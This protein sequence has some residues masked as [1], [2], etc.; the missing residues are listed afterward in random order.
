MLALQEPVTLPEM[1]DVLRR[2]GF[3]R[4]FAGLL[5]LTLP[6]AVVLQDDEAS[7]YALSALAGMGLYPLAL[8][9]GAL[10]GDA[11]RRGATPPPRVASLRRWVVGLRWSLAF[12]WGAW[13]AGGHGRYGSRAWLTALVALAAGASAA[14]AARPLPVT[15]RP[16]PDTS[17]TTVSPSRI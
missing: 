7:W 15:D 9:A 6:F 3:G 4:L 5:A 8:R 17:T 13:A 10:R 2:L 14:Y 12:V 16:S 1:D 11:E